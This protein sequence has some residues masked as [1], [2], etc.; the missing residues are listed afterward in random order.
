MARPPMMMRAPILMNRQSPLLTTWTRLHR[1]YPSW[2]SRSLAKSG[3]R[4]PIL[5]GQEHF[6]W[7][8]L[9]TAQKRHELSGFDGQ[10]AVHVAAGVDRVDGVGRPR[11]VRR[12]AD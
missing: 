10:R 8:P 12:G 5:Q 4:H 1:Q 6:L 3:R 9:R 11:T 7:L 2:A